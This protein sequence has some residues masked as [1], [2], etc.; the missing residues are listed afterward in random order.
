MVMMMIVLYDLLFVVAFYVLI[1]QTV[2]K[3]AEGEEALVLVSL[4]FDSCQWGGET[5]H[6][7]SGGLKRGYL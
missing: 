5:S 1:L 3:G 4:E 6:T 2:T 7:R